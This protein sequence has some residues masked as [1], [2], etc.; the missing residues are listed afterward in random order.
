MRNRLGRP[1]EGV[2]RH[3]HRI[4]VILPPGPTIQPTALLANATLQ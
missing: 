3:G 4:L 1:Q 2:R